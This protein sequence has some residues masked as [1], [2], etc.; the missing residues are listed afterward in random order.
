MLDY[1]NKL[2]SGFDFSN[3]IRNHFLENKQPCNFKKTGTT[4]CGFLFKD[5]IVLASDTRASAG[6]MVAQKNINKFHYLA[7]NAYS[8]GAGTAADNDLV[9]LK[10]SHELELFS[11]NTKKLP[12]AATILTKLSDTLFRHMGQLGVYQ[13]IG[14]FDPVDGP[15][16]YN[17]SSSGFYHEKV[18]VTSGSG[19]LAAM[20]II[21]HRHNIN[22]TKEEA[23]QLAIDAISAGIEYDLGSGSNVNVAIIK[24]EGVEIIMKAKDTAKQE[25]KNMKLNYVKNNIST[26]IR[27]IKGA[28]IGY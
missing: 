23:I 19:S 1:T 16:L 20:S 26:I 17:I 4:L 10:L 8:C 9:L 22:M 25:H 12:R 21:E 2:S 14:I 27:G 28:I 6:A 3:T 24:K 11:L 5:G 15:K 7:K 18:R 13:I